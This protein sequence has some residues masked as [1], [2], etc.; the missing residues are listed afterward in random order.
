MASLDPEYMTFTY[1]CEF[2]GIPGPDHDPSDY[3]INWTAS[4]S[5]TV[6][7]DED[8]GGDG[9]EVHVGEAH[10]SIVPDAGEID[11]FDTLDAVDQVLANVAEMLT[12]QRPDL[13]DAAC[14]DLGGDLLVLSSLYIDPKFR[15]HKIGHSILNAILATVGRDSAMV[16]LQ[17]A[18]V[19][20]EDGPREG[21][22]EHAAAKAA[23]RRYWIDYGF[24]GADGDYL[25]LA[26]TSDVLNEAELRG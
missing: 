13:L 10:F 20:T 2:R 4:I 22:P 5:A 12:T 1:K 14:L 8:H 25:V 26:A 18:P 15:G 9:E 6:W 19:L 21:S 16:V 7:D 11:L 17:A 24:Q 3:A 23:L